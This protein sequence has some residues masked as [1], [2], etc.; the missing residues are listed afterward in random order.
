MGSKATNTELDGIDA[1]YPLRAR[2]R[3]RVLPVLL[4]GVAAP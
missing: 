2:F 4:V 3:M 1:P